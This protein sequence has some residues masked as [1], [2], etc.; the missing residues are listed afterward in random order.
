M[1]VWFFFL[2]LANCFVLVHENI[3]EH[4]GVICSPHKT[5]MCLVVPFTSR[6]NHCP[7]FIWKAQPSYGRPNLHM[8]GVL[9]HGR[10]FVIGVKKNHKGKNV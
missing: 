8:E 5:K 3:L 10:C 9:S 6:K 2:T 4:V 1:C 7:T